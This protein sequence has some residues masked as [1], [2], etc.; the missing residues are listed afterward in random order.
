[1]DCFACKMISVNH[2]DDAHA[3]SGKSYGQRITTHYEFD[4]ITGGDGWILTDHIRERTRSGRLFFRRPGVTVE[5]ITPYSCYFFQF[6]TDAKIDL[7]TSTIDFTEPRV[8][9]RLFDRAYGAFL[10][11]DKDFSYLFQVT[12][13]EIILQTMLRR[14]MPTE[15]KAE[16]P[17]AIHQ[18]MEYLREHYREPITLESVSKHFG[19][20]KYWFSHAFQT[21]HGV[22]PMAYLRSIR[23]IE[24][25]RLLLE[26]SL[27]VQEIRL[28]C[29]YSDEAAF[30]RAFRKFT[31]QSPG[32]FRAQYGLSRSSV[33][34]LCR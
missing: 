13:N 28:R 12:I 17:E 10:R 31:G 34:N 22:A 27:S 24:A 5:G 2:I 29:G 8:L 18:A 9:E 7:P 26:T 16:T 33:G 14:S 4:F 1:M 21:T 3:V 19:Y 25:R 15:G 11:Q 30:Y 20:S 23:L 32:A 6:D